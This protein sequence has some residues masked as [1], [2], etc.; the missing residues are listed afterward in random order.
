MN[1]YQK[2]EAAVQDMKIPDNRKAANPPNA[3][4]FLRSGVA[5][6]REHKNILAAIFHAR[7]IAN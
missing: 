2:F 4:W 3:L 7:K 1:H 5:Y 6:N